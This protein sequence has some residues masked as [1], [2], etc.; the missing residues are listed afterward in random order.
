M[1]FVWINRVCRRAAIG[2]LIANTA[3]RVDLEGERKKIG[4]AHRL[5]SI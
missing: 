1:I 4:E 3:D 2:F 5:W